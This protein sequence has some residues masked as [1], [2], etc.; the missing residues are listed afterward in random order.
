MN[1]VTNCFSN[2]HGIASLFLNVG[3]GAAGW[4]VRCCGVRLQTAR[5]DVDFAVGGDTGKGAA[6]GDGWRSSGGEV[7]L[8][9]AVARVK[10]VGADARH[11]VRNGDAGQAVAILERIGAD[12]RHAI[13]DGDAGQAVAIVKRAAADARHAV[14]NGDAGQT[15]AILER[16]GADACHAVR[17][18]DAGQAVAILE[19]TAADA[20]HAVRNA[21]AGQT[22]AIVE[23]AAA[24]ACH[25]VRDSDT[26]KAI[27]TVER[28]SADTRHAV[29]DGD[30]GKAEATVECAA[31]DA[32][33]A[34]R[35]IHRPH[36]VLVHPV[37]AIRARRMP[38]QPAILIART[39]PIKPHR[40]RTRQLYIVISRRGVIV[41][42]RPLHRCYRRARQRIVGGPVAPVHVHRAVRTNTQYGRR[43]A[44]LQMNQ[45]VGLAVRGFIHLPHFQPPVF[46]DI[47]LRVL[48]RPVPPL[49]RQRDGVA[50]VVGIVGHGGQCGELGGGV[51]ID[52]SAVV[53]A[54]INLFRGDRGRAA[55]C[56]NGIHCT[57]KLIRERQRIRCAALRSDGVCHF[58]QVGPIN[59]INNVPNSIVIRK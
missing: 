13:R 35:A 51:G 47:R 55:A 14:R 31:A 42:R 48:K 20:C 28:I 50:A 39:V 59:S 56:R 38:Q 6:D 18:A 22:I 3:V 45:H 37:P 2:N 32:C 44:L 41:R 27:A 25:A 34:V 12:A 33:H 11:A 46:R 57:H 40:P 36:C 16:V 52:H 21:D 26:G 10:R 23:R 7:Q 19:R 1:A 49:R 8:G 5:R 4:I 9:E 53:V 17:N 24:D 29:R 54:E 30:T 15:G 58:C 43:A